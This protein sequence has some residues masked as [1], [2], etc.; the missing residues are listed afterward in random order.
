M[1]EMI[2]KIPD[3]FTAEQELFIKKSAFNQIE[4]EMKKVLV[5]PAEEIEA[6]QTEV[7]ILRTAM[8][9]PTEKEVEDAKL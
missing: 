7:D 9:L 8:E 6:V 1:K 5:I 3:D 2:I 4:A